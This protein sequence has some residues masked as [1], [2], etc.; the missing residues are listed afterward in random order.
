MANERASETILSA[1]FGPF[2]VSTWKLLPVIEAATRKQAYTFM[3][4]DAY[5]AL[6]HSQPERAQAIYW[7][8]GHARSSRMLRL[9]VAP[10]RM[11]KHAFDSDRGR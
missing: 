3:D 11:A 6:V 10:S 4:K 5:D 8:D 7:R 9:F 1:Y 2:A